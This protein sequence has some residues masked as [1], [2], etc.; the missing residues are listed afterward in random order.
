MEHIWSGLSQKYVP[1]IILGVFMT[2]IIE[3]SFIFRFPFL[4]QKFFDIR[5]F[6]EGK[7]KETRDDFTIYILH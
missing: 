6:I 2:W 3:T 4:L 7:S 1:F 5:N